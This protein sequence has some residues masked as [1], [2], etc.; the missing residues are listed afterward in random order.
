MPRISLDDFEGIYRQHFDALAQY[1]F[2]KLDQISDAEDI[3]QTVFQKLYHALRKRDRDV[4]NIE[5]YL[6]QMANF[7][8]SRFY[9]SK[10]PAQYSL[11]DPHASMIEPQDDQDIEKEI[12]DRCAIDVLVR[13]VKDLPPED[14]RILVAKVKWEMTFQEMA[15]H[16]KRPEN[17]IKTHYYRILRKLKESI[18][19]QERSAYE[20]L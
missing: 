15:H 5:A 10:A 8:L 17:S 20:T 4:D 14:Q 2:F 1:V 19:S 18:Q 16:F 3:V 7:E 12:L 9:K 13:C 11:D 6:T